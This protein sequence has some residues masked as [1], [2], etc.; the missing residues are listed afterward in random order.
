M[1]KYHNTPKGPRSCRAEKGLCPYG[2]AGGDHYETQAEAQAAYEK[3]MGEAFGLVP[4]HSK[5]EQKRQNHYQRVDKIRAFATKVT[6]AATQAKASAIYAVSKENRDRLKAKGAAR[7]IQL[8]QNMSDAAATAYRSAREEFVM[9][10]PPRYREEVRFAVENPREKISQEVARMKAGAASV[11]DGVR[12]ARDEGRQ[13]LADGHAVASYAN[14]S[15]KKRFFNY[16]SKASHRLA[17]KSD[18]ILENKYTRAAPVAEKRSVEGTPFDRP[19]MIIP[20]AAARVIVVP[21]PG[22]G[23]AEVTYGGVPESWVA[24]GKLGS[25]TKEKVLA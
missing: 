5:L 12:R 24:S 13:L 1:A 11:A 17:A 14:Y 16:V 22:K 10:T 20:E 18:F 3:K 21:P 4:A 2:R 15:L 6:D 23:E 19:R 8:R 9:S 7:A 25:E